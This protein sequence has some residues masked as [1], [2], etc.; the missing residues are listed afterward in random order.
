MIFLL[1]TRTRSRRKQ[2]LDA[3]GQY[4]TRLV[5][6]VGVVLASD[7]CQIFLRNQRAVELEVVSCVIKRNTHKAQLLTMFV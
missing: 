4:L 6:K 3:W 7:W 2:G 5:L 1:Y